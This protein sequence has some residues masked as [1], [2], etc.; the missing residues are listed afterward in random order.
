[1]NWFD[2]GRILYETR[3][4]EAW[5]F[6]KGDGRAEARLARHPYP[7]HPADADP[8]CQSAEVELAQAQARALLKVCVV[9]QVA[10]A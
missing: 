6:S 9:Q 3:I 8:A 10:H 2:L 7:R 5:T 4:R 1:M